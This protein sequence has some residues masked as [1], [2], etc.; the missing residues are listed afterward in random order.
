MTS[1]KAAAEFQLEK[2][3]KGIQEAQVEVERSRGVP[4]R[5]S[6]IWEED[7]DMKALEPLP[8]HHR[9]LVGAS[10]QLQMAAK[11][12]LKVLDIKSLNRLFHFLWKFGGGYC[13]TL[14]RKSMVYFDKR[15]GLS[16]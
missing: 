16:I 8:F 9:H 4:R 7:V 10:I 14:I 15:M 11:T 3:M 1:E 13:Y 6:S 12:W 5:A 2:E